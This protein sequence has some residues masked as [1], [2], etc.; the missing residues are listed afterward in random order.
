LLLSRP[1]ARMLSTLPPA[2][3]AAT[4]VHDA[5]LNFTTL[6]LTN[7]EKHNA[8]SDVTIQLLSS[9]LAQVPSTSRGLFVRSTGKSFCAGGDVAYMRKLAR[10][11][12]AENKNDALA[13]ARLL[14]QLNGMPMPTVA[15]VQ[16]PAYGGGVGLIA[17][18]DLSVAVKSATFA[19]SE[20]KLGLIPATISPYVV[21]KLGPHHAKRY[22][23]T[24][25]A[26]DAARAQSIGLVDELVQSPAELDEWQ[27]KLS[28]A[29]L[30]N[31]PQAVRDCKSLVRLVLEHAGAVSEELMDQTADRLARARASAEG[32]EGV[33]AFLEKR[34]PA[35]LGPRQQAAAAAA[36]RLE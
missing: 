35:W 23:M 31:A 32:I 22:F 3:A 29:L 17:A 28:E 14:R 34:S 5:S 21:Q 27:G 11:T 16:G 24:A 20:V 10:A 6:T 30:R 33:S 12:P 36:K 7:P 25:E 1:C 8:F 2:A 15:L 13:L 26:F 9:L 19:L 4:L 18:C